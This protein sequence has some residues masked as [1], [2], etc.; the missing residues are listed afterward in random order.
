ME[1]ADDRPARHAAG[2]VGA[3]ARDG[4][5]AAR[6]RSARTCLL[7]AGDL[8][9]L[10]RLPRRRGPTARRRAVRVPLRHRP[11]AGRDRRRRS[12]PSTGATRCSCRAGSRAWRAGE[13]NEY[14]YNFFKSLSVERMRRA[15][16]EAVRKLD[17]EPNAARRRARHPPRR[18]HR[19]APLPAPQRRPRR[20]RRDRRRR[21]RLHAARLALRPRHRPLPHVVRSARQDP[22]R[23]SEI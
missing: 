16:A 14:V 4:A 22:T 23:S 17:P 8:D 20:V 18:L 15:E 2:V 9:I 3:A 19:A 7:R 11:R 12:A 13:F 6:R 1:P 10:H 5:D 21:A